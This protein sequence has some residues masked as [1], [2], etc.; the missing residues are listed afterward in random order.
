MYVM[1]FL[2]GQAGC[3]WPRL[4]GFL[5]V[6]QHKWAWSVCGMATSSHLLPAKPAPGVTAPA[7]RVPPPSTHHHPTL[8]AITPTWSH[9]T[10]TIALPPPTPAVRTTH[11]CPY[12]RPVSGDAPTALYYRC[13]HLVHP[14]PR[15]PPNHPHSTDTFCTF[16]FSLQVLRRVSLPA[17]SG[18]GV[19][20][21]G[22][23]SNPAASSPA[24]GLSPAL[25]PKEYK[26]EE[27][28][29]KAIRTFKDV[30]GCDEAKEEL[31]EVVEFLKNP[32]ASGSLSVSLPCL[33]GSFA[34]SLIVVVCGCVGWRWCLP[35]VLGCRSGVIRFIFV[36][37]CFWSD[38][39]L[40]VKAAAA[41]VS[42]NSCCC[43]ML[44]ATA[45]A[46]AESAAVA[47]AAAAAAAKF[48][49]LGAKLPKGVLLT[50]PPGTGKTLLARAV[51]GALCTLYCTLTL[52]AYTSD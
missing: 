27:L 14:S 42:C 47:T 33:S 3:A 32:G 8:P 39:L 13:T 50:G 35:R 28:P 22:A 23:A 24:A 49:R 15:T 17:G 26:R 10:A 31:R 46:P 6:L 16:S 7:S 51:A 18:A 29:E 44:A 5:R 43:S 25:D 36:A 40:V 52:L 4:L 45:A 37:L 48:T 11:M 19:S 21:A 1:G 34:V 38:T 9:H 2:M 41:M 12:P 20:A 30:V